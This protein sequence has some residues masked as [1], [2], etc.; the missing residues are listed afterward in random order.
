MIYADSSFFVSNYIADAHSLE[1]EKRIR[2]RREI[3]VT[4]LN[5][6]EFA[7]AVWQHVRRANAKESVAQFLCKSFDDD[8]W[9]GIWHPVQIPSTAWERCFNM[10]TKYGNQIP[11]RTLDAL[12]VVCA[13]EL[14]AEHFWSFDDRQLKLAELCGLKT[15]S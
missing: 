13:L 5:R 10:P 1:V 14:N 6:A 8:C 2:N 3:W 4:Q 15:A 11:F 9:N 12:H 7:N